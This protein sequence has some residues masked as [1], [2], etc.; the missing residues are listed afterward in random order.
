MDEKISL[1]TS[2]E[3]VARLYPEAVGYLTRRG[4]RCI[5]C[6]EPL[7]CT[8]GELFRDDKVPDPE[9]LLADLNDFLAKTY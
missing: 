2:V 9:A 4:V 8:M 5:R 6:G 7:W 1:A 3:D